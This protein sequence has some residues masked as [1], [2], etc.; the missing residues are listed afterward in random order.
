MDTKEEDKKEQEEQQE[1]LNTNESLDIEDEDSKE[2]QEEDHISLG[3][4][5]EEEQSEAPEFVKALAEQAREKDKR[6]RE[7]EQKLEEVKPKEEAPKQIEKPTL[8]SCEFDEDVYSQKMQEYLNAEN[9]KNNEIEEEKKQWNKVLERYE[10][11]KNSL[12]VAN[13][14]ESEEAV[15]SKLTVEQQ[16]IIVNGAQNPATLVYALGK[17]SKELD[18]LAKIKDPIKF[19]FAVAELQGKVKVQKRRPATSPE[20][21]P[22]AGGAGGVDVKLEQLR[23]EAEK[24]GDFTK[25]FKYKK[26]LNKKG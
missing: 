6:I 1:E 9:A 18:K 17:N 12:K 13:Y 22:S 16:A 14:Q 15:V 21:I 24:T 8:E 5:Q 11:E 10:H 20:K 2:E 23:K 3:E 19:A 26:E 4:E 7:L 25:V